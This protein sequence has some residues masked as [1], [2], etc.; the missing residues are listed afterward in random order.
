MV[1]KPIAHIKNAYKTKFAIPRQSRLANSKSLIVFEKEFAS[2][3]ALRGIDGYS[4]LWLIWDFSEAHR[5]EWSPTVRPPRL[6]GNKRMGVF[7]TR[8]PYRPNQIGLSCVKLISVDISSNIPTL[9]V[10]GADLMDGTPIYDI[11]P[12]I[13]F[14]DSVPDAICGFADDVKDEHLLLTVTDT[15]LQKIPHSERIALIDILAGDPRP[16]YHHDSQRLYGFEYLGFEIKFNVDGNM[17]EVVSITEA[18]DHK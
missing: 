10:E 2:K 4:H 9:T 14:T 12:Y 11:K 8:S 13:A 7:A 1:I 15:L 5:D 6:G 3:D 16:S 17:L 18:H